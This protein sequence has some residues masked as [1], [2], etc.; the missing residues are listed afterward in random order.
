MGRWTI[1]HAMG[2][3]AQYVRIKY[4]TKNMVVVSPDAGHAKVAPHGREHS[5][6]RFLGIHSQDRPARSQQII[7]HR[8]IGDVKG[9]TCVLIDDMI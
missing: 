1:C 5:G 2:K 7:A 6:R 3:L 8:V 9:R 4:G